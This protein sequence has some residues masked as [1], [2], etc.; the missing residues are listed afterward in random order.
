MKKVLKNILLL[1]L[2]GLAQWRIANGLEVGYQQKQNGNLLP[3]VEEKIIYI[4]G[5]VIP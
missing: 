5:E 2:L 3:E 1:I 4:V